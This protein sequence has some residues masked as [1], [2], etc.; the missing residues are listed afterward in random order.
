MPLQRSEDAC[1]WSALRVAAWAPSSHEV[2]SPLS[3][4]YLVAVA[5]YWLRAPSTPLGR[6]SAP[7]ILRS[8]SYQFTLRVHG[9]F[10]RSQTFRLFRAIEVAHRRS[11]CGSVSMLPPTHRHAVHRSSHPPSIPW[12]AP[13]LRFP[14]PSALSIWRVHFSSND[15][16]TPLRSTV[17][18]LPHRHLSTFR[19]SHPLGGFLL[20]GPHRPV[21][22]DKRSWGLRPSELFPPQQPYRLVGD[23]V[24]S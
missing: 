6:L 2:R 9:G 23:H 17:T 13:L 22:S 14:S 24:P 16:A 21:S 3:V 10:I 7:W 15:A 1:W 18:E 19:V 5:R 8:F 20:S 12:M 11:P 4:L